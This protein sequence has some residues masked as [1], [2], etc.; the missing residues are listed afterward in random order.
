MTMASHRLTSQTEPPESYHST[1]QFRPRGGDTGARAGHL[2]RQLSSV[3]ERTR[4]IRSDRQL[5]EHR[6]PTR[7]AMSPFAA[8]ARLRTG[9]PPQALPPVPSQPPTLQDEQLTDGGN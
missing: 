9:C 8:A 3:C 2:D 1:D 7:R 5:C 4:H 6:V